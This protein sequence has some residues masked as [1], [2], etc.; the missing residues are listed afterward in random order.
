MDSMDL[1]HDM[2]IDVDL[3]ADQ[4]I[5]PEPEPTHHSDGEIDEDDADPRCP[6][7]I[8]LRGLDVMNAKEVK[9]YVAE[10]CSDSNV[11]LDR[12]EWIDDTSANLVF[13][14]Q[15]MASSALVA[16]AVDPIADISHLSARQLLRARE[17]SSKPD[18]ALQ[19]RPARESDRKEVGA[20]SRSRFYLLNPEYDPE[21]RRRRNETRRYRDRNGDGY[22]RNHGRRGREDETDEP[23]DVNLYDDS[24]APTETRSTRDR[25]RRRRSL[26]P[27]NETTDL[28]TDSYRPSYSNRGKEL[29]P[30]DI[31]SRNRSASPARDRDGDQSM[32]DTANN[33]L[34][35]VRDRNRSRAHALKSHTSRQNR[36]RE[37]FPTAATG[38]SGRLDDTVE[39]TAVLLSK[40][41]MLPL[42]DGSNDT[43]AAAGTSRRLEDRITVPGKRSLA[44]RVTLPNSTEDSAFNIRGMAAQRSANTGFAIKGQA[45][46]SVKELFPDKFGSNAGKE[47]FGNAPS[48]GR[49]RQRK[50]AGDLFD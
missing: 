17:F 15:D 14:S 4:P 39:D 21:E 6:S 49:N 47:L 40:G 16:L 30:D 3:V 44:D 24:P 42:M 46:K 11:D 36:V 22:S 41:I 7:K 33:G 38:D 43:P 26:T 37:L 31:G 32:D 28:M 50:K 2:D 29:F 27:E 48:G 45:G 13:A 34:A 23:F 12:I 10:H 20:A 18:V 25:P 35:G 9:A 1:D 5:V 8:Y 19:L